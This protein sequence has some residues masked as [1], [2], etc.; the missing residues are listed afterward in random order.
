MDLATVEADIKALVAKV[1]AL[2]KG[3]ASTVTATSWWSKYRLWIVLGGCIV[4][5][6]AVGHMF[7]SH[8][9]Q[10]FMGS[11]L[12]SASPPSTCVECAAMNTKLTS[13]QESLAQLAAFAKMASAKMS[14]PAEVLPAPDAPPAAVHKKKPPAKTSWW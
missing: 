6:L 14:A 7:M 5:A 8:P 2:V 9:Q 1:E 12:M 11:S 10:K 13:M 3:G 4:L